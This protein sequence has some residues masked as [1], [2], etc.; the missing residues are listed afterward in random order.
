MVTNL[1]EQQ[2]DICPAWD[3]VS[4]HG[5][6]CSSV[7]HLSLF[8]VENQTLFLARSNGRK[9]SVDS[10]DI[11]QSIVASWTFEQLHIGVS[12]TEYLFTHELCH[13]CTASLEVLKF[14]TA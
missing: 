1:H 7:S 3:T 9:L 14:M 5:S 4:H 6:V 11:V 12:N 2:M 10:Q 8:G 13:I